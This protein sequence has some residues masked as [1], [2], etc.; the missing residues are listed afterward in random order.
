MPKSKE[1][2]APVFRVHVTL[3]TVEASAACTELPS[4]GSYVPN[5]RGGTTSRQFAMTLAVTSIRPPMESAA[6][7]AAVMRLTA[8]IN[9]ISFGLVIV[10]SEVTGS[11]S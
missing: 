6:E 2:A 8:T 7:I 4:S 5:E 9:A 1:T 11:L 3:M 10:V